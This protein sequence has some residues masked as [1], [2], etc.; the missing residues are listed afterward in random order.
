MSLEFACIHVPS[1]QGSSELAAAL[2]ALARE[3]SPRVELRRDDTVLLDAVGLAR[4]FGGARALGEHLRQAAAA[5]GLDVSVA[6]ASTKTTAMMT[7]AGR[8]GVTVVPAGREAAA[9]APL[10]LSVLHLFEDNERA[11]VARQLVGGSQAAT[12]EDE[13]TSARHYRIAPG[14]GRQWQAPRAP[15]LPSRASPPVMSMALAILDRWGL[16]TCGE[17]AALPPA[18]LY[19]RLG[20]T[21]TRLRRLARGDD[22][23]PLVRAPEDERFEQTLDL[24]WPIEGLEPLS[25]VLARLLDPLS[26]QLERRDRGAAAI[27]V[28]LTLVTRTVHHRWLDLPVPMRDARV[29]RTLLLLDL[30]SHPPPAGIDRVTIAAEPAPGRV[31]QFSLLARPLPSSDQVSTLMARLTALMGEGR[32]GSPALVDSHCPGAFAVTAFSPEQAPARLSRG[33]PATNG[34][35]ARL[36]DESMLDTGVGL[37]T[38]S[39]LRRFRHPLMASVTTEGG[40]PVHVA[41]RGTGLAG[42]GVR[43][44]SGPWRTSGGWW[45]VD[46]DGEVRA[47]RG[48]AAGPGQHDTRAGQEGRDASSGSEAS[49]RPRSPHAVPAGRAA[50]WDRDEWDVALGD[51]AV[52]RVFR[53]RRTKR[54][55]VEGMW[56]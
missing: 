32:C 33:S 22:D 39:V 56:D 13:T 16:A 12:V 40:H 44:A 38:V 29:L 27:H 41:P 35:R 49:G 11:D 5:R 20:D 1:A 48:G 4:L 26:A 45:S 43:V 42:G 14:P 2:L 25:F 8:H 53:D 46:T 18:D 37:A 31:A 7:A 51:R 28:W 23:R 54:W 50:C 36:A 10:P 9:L 30:E 15:A 3:C 52:Y 47:D 17:L 55:Y 6:L 24:D 19:E 34:D 21:G